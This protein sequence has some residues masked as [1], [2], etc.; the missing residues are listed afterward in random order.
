MTDMKPTEVWF[1]N[2]KVIHRNLGSYVFL[3]LPYRD[4]IA[5]TDE[6]AM[7]WKALLKPMTVGDLHTRMAQETN[8]YKKS[9]RS[10]TGI[11]NR[12]RQLGFVLK[13]KIDETN[14]RSR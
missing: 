13:E 8:N 11:L 7:V 5:V 9:V 2:P 12:L 10:L 1:R 4:I 14:N 3:S 6:V